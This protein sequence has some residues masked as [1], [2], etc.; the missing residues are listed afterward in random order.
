MHINNQHIIKQQHTAADWV[1]H[2]KTH[3][4]SHEQLLKLFF[5]AH[6]LC[7]RHKNRS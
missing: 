2:I 1:I 7:H 4:Y 6:G 5:Q 3:L